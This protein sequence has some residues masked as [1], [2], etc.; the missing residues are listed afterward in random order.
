MAILIDSLYICGFEN[1]ENL[2]VAL[3]VLSQKPE[4]TVAGTVQVFHLIPFYIPDRNP[5]YHQLHC[6]VTNK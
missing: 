2:S 4:I 1:Y 3:F 5:E 6:K